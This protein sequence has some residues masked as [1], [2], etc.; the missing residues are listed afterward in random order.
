MKAKYSGQSDSL[1][2]LNGKVYEVI[3]VEDGP[4]NTKWYRVIDETGDDYL[5]LSD[6]FEIVED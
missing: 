3:S 2:L 6:D 1:M 5:Y 4:S